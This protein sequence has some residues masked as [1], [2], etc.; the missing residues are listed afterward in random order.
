MKPQQKL[1]ALSYW[2]RYILEWLSVL[3]LIF[4]AAYITQSSRAIELT[5][6]YV[7]DRIVTWQESAPNPEVVIIGVDDYS[8]QQIGRWPW[9]RDVH[10]KL[11]EKLAL[12][13][14]RGVFFDFLLTEPTTDDVG[15]GQKMAKVQNVVLPVELASY[16]GAPPVVIE[17]VAAVARSSQLGHIVVHPDSDGV[18]R[19]VAL[20][21]KDEHGRSWPLATRLMLPATSSLS[22]NDVIRI[23]FNV[24]KGAFPVFP[25]AGVISGEVPLE[26][27]KDKVV[28]V[29]A[30]AFGLGDQ[31][32]TPISGSAGLVSGVEVHA[33]I[34]NSLILG[35]QINVVNQPELT[36]LNWALPLLLLMLAFFWFEERYHVLFLIT[37]AATYI[38]LV[39]YLLTAKNMWLPPM[40][41]LWVMV[42]A[43]F[44]WS[45]RRLSVVL[46]YVR[47][48]LRN[49]EAERKSL[50]Q[51]ISSRK[52]QWF[53][54]RS[55]ERGMQR[56]QR[57]YQFTYE[58]LELMPTALLVATKNGEIVL[59]NRDAKLQFGDEQS[60]VASLLHRIDRY[61]KPSGSDD[62]LSELHGV[63]LRTA[64]DRV[65][66]LHVNVVA[67]DEAGLV[68]DNADDTLWLMHFLEL[69]EERRAQKQ[70]SELMEF[71]SHDLRSPQVAILALLDLQK[72]PATRVSEDELHHRITVR[73]QHTLDWAYDLARLSHARAGQYRL[74]TMS[75]AT[76]LDDAIEQVSPQMHAKSLHL[77]L[78]SPD[79]AEEA[80]LKVDGELMV[81]AIVNILSNSIRYS[82]E[83]AELNIQVRIDAST[84][85][86][87]IIDFGCGMDEAQAQQLLHG[88]VSL[89]GIAERNQPDAARSMGVGFLMAR[90]VVQRHGG[91]LNII[92]KLKQGT[93]VEINLPLVADEQLVN[94]IDLGES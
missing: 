85:T 66:V 87:S 29:G 43:Y 44:L 38:G 30:T 63:E 10:Q 25:Y 57:L 82:D 42:L 69:S 20:N 72:N 53:A 71:L 45:W 28:L 65:F 90:T 17:P 7:Y 67:F 88:Q 60:D 34:L 47:V 91:H 21:L 32:I 51:L 36:L 56:V 52:Q 4:I 74:E 86:C 9:S 5:N 3:S 37:M 59:S 64:D 62:W 81:R 41:A 93:T 2:R 92:S 12:A 58:S 76:V 48:N 24:P 13:K 55:I 78:L 15:L 70:R 73:V 22:N 84:V 83:G 46:G 80:W 14:P 8:L 11:F 89:S 6:D 49:A 16:G 35:N 40:S 33:N 94:E 61:W 79:L 19:E 54:P 39:L 23:P 77:T 18:L 31:Y 68:N 26:F 50:T 75:L 27:F 1:S